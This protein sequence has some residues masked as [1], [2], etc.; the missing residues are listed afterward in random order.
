M[1]E[2]RPRRRRKLSP[3]E[4]KALE[5]QRKKQQALY[6]KRQKQAAKEREA[7]RKKAKKAGVRIDERPPFNSERN[8]ERNP[9][10][11][12]QRRPGGGAEYRPKERIRRMDIA[13]SGNKSYDDNNVEVQNIEV[14]GERPLVTESKDKRRNR[15]NERKARGKK[16]G[17]KSMPDIIEKET[18]KRVRGLEATDHK[19][20]FYADEVEIRKAQARK[21]RRKRRKKMP[22]PISPQKRRAR[23]IFA[24]VTIITTVIVVGVVLSLT[25]LF[26]TENIYVEGNKYYTEDTLIRLAK[27]REGD[28]IFMATMFGD[29]SAVASNLPYIKSAGIS[30][31]LPNSLV[32]TVENAKESYSMK[33]DGIYYKVSEENRILEQET[34]KPKKLASLIAPALKSTKI[35]D[36]VEFKDKAYTKA[37][38]DLSECIKKNNYKKITEINIKKITEISITYDKRIKIKIGLPEAIEYKLKTAFA[39]ITEKLDINNS[40]TTKGVLDVSKCNKTKKSYFK[41]GSIKENEEVLTQPTTAVTEETTVRATY[42]APETEEAAETEE[43]NDEENYENDENNDEN[44]DSDNEEQAETE[45]YE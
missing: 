14:K 24:Y 41:E 17:K 45:A 26:K 3:K 31:R 39:I 42:I 38:D 10:Q 8:P 23:K 40:R 36:K 35:G 32:L 29:A 19:D 33:T 20:G 6:Q 2:K 44:V 1:D 28:N 4:L 30:F 22:K 34:K 12:G 25:V 15:N 5:K 43:Q 13:G 11:L 37:L 27:I 9:E 16:R 7:V 18:D 21:E